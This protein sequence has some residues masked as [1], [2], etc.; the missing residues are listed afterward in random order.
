MGHDW[1]CNAALAQSA[2]VSCID[3]CTKQALHRISYMKLWWLWSWWFTLIRCSADHFC[4]FI[5][6]NREHVTMKKKKMYANIHLQSNSCSPKDKSYN[7]MLSRNY[8]RFNARTSKRKKKH[9]GKQW[10]ASE[11]IIMEQHKHFL[12]CSQKLSQKKRERHCTKKTIQKFASLLWHFRSIQTL[13]RFL[14]HHVMLDDK[15]VNT[16]TIHFIAVYFSGWQQK[17]YHVQCGKHIE[18]NHADNDTL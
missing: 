16:V 2:P 7:V 9:S 12:Q 5:R 11:H 14:P 15:I 8:K 6:R 10:Y 1:S 3:S 18:S 17:L 4:F 13:L